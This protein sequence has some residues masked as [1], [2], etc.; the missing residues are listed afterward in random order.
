LPAH[1][2]FKTCGNPAS[3]TAGEDAAI[4]EFGVCRGGSLLFLAALAQRLLPNVELAGFDTWSGIPAGGADPYVD[5]HREA[6]LPKSK[7]TLPICSDWPT[8]LAMS[9]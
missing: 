8:G 6:N 9:R 1:T 2:E 3:L 7:A 5:W 4:V